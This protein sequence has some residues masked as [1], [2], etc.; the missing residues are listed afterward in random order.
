MENLANAFKAPNFLLLPVAPR[1][2]SLPLGSGSP[3]IMVGRA[4]S[5]TPVGWMLMSGPRPSSE[6]AMPASAV[7]LYKWLAKP[8]L[9]LVIPSLLKPC[10]GFGTPV[11]CPHFQ[12]DLASIPSFSLRPIIPTSSLTTFYQAFRLLIHLLSF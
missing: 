2:S 3:S 6:P 8:Q 1:K 5:E 7:C 4:R 12:K 10:P 9:P 11:Q